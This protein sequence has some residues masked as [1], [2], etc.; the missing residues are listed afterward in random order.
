MRNRRACGGGQHVARGHIPDP[1]VLRRPAPKARAILANVAPQVR[2]GGT[3]L[4]A[5]CTLTREEGDA[6][7]EDLLREKTKFRF[8]PHEKEPRV[9]LRPDRD[10]TDGFMVFRLRRVAP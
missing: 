5:V 7:V 8:V 6:V 1:R 10:E 9:V 2:N 4:Y 3:L